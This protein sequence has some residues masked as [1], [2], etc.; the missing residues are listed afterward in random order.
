MTTKFR[1]R[2][3][4]DARQHK[5]QM[6][7]EMLEPCSA[8]LRRALDAVAKICEDDSYRRV[9]VAQREMREL[10]RVISVH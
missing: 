1:G 10:S 5:E 4:R 7:Q 2:A 3:K 6:R 9:A 8:N